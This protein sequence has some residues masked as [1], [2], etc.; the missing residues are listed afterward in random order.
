[1]VTDW[2]AIGAIAAI[3]GVVIA[4]WQLR[5]MYKSPVVAMSNEGQNTQ[6][7]VETSAIATAV[8]RHDLMYAVDVSSTSVSE[9]L[10]NA[11]IG[12]FTAI[13]RLNCSVITLKNDNSDV[14]QN[15]RLRFTVWGETFATEVVSTS[16]LAKEAIS[17]M[18]D[19][20]TIQ[21]RIDQFPDGEEVKI[22]VFSIGQG[23]SRQIKSE[24][25]HVR[26]KGIR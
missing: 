19:D 9:K 15:V 13:S 8:A 12:R 23:P 10:A 22:A 17:S 24:N 3:V 1:M 14:I 18:I 4:A 2:G 5:R 11:A 16:S 6:R 26:L 7:Q 21:I 25:G 20:S